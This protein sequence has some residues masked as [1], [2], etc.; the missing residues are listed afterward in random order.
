MSYTWDYIQKNPKQTKRL[1][2]INH[3]QLYQLIE[4]A[5]LLHRQH[6]EK[7]QNQKVRLIKPGGGASQKLSLS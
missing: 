2:G 4:Q 7:N 3:E 6:K 1:L 5:K